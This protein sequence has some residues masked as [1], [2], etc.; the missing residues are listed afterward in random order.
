[1]NGVSCTSNTQ[2][3]SPTIAPTSVAR[4]SIA[5]EVEYNELMT[6]NCELESQAA[7]HIRGRDEAQS[8][9]CARLLS[10]CSFLS[11]DDDVSWA[12][13]SD[14]DSILIWETCC[15]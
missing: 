9:T 7:N 2:A 5:D 10:P 4:D 13:Y 8:A 11:L 12:S 15:S 14:I 3:P 6:R 1:M